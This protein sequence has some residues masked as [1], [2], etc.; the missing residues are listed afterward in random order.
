[1]ENLKEN[2]NKPLSDLEIILLEK[3]LIPKKQ[4]KNSLRI[5]IYLGNSRP[6]GRFDFGAELLKKIDREGHYIAGIIVEKNDPV[7]VYPS[8]KAKKILLLPEV[9]TGSTVSIKDKMSRPEFKTQFDDF[10]KKLQSCAADVGIVF[11]GFW[12]PPEIYTIPRYGFLNYH[13]GPLPF[14]RGMEPDTFAVIEGW[15]KIWG[16]LH[17]VE[18]AFDTGN[19]ITKSKIIKIRKY[20]TPLSILKKLTEAGIESITG[21]LKYLHK[22]KCFRNIV[23]QDK[24]SHATLKM[25]YEKSFINWD[26]DSNINLDRKLRAF[27]GQNINIRLKAPF[28]NNY[29]IVYDIELFKG[30]FPGTPG[31]I[32]GYYTGKSKFLLQPIVRTI[33][34][35]A[36][37]FTGNQISGDSF[38]EEGDYADLIIPPRKRKKET[39]KSLVKK[40]IAVFS[41]YLN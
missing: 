14:L 3:I 2:Q 21:T 26:N 17:K 41:K 36:V 24:G 40:S 10:L 29:Y 23:L 8:L 31:I 15:K 6:R 18:S 5:I 4:K 16:T 38:P 12:I 1:M 33:D 20:D 13:P 34:G 19:I 27:C 9:L 11:Y 37:L 39:K 30:N 35:A 22:H 7:I 28:N 32:I 25:A